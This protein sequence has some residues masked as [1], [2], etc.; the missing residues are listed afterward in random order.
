MKTH[1]YS[2]PSY[3]HSYEGNFDSQSCG[4]SLHCTMS[5]R[6]TVVKELQLRI[7][8][9][10]FEKIV[11]TLRKKSFFCISLCAKIRNVEVSRF[12]HEAPH[13]A[14][15]KPITCLRLPM[16]WAGRRLNGTY[17]D[18]Y[19]HFYLCPFVGGL[20]NQT[21]FDKFGIEDL[22]RPKIDPINFWCRSRSRDGSRNSFSL[23]FFLNIV[24]WGVL[25]HVQ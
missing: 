22:S 7:K 8:F 10:N 6:L 3:M 20:V 18:L 1:Y 11:S 21:N 12:H 5:T 13:Y 2:G 15:T 24:R 19:I 23:S 9:S 14:E 16:H 17:G 25:Q 4:R